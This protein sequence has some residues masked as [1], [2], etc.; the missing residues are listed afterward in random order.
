MKIKF[1][2][3]VEMA[4][5]P[6]VEQKRFVGGVPQGW[7]LMFNIMGQVDSTALDIVLT[8]ENMSELKFLNDSDD[9]ITTTH[10]YEKVLSCTI[11]HG[12]SPSDTRTEIQLMKN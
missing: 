6:P 4:C 2:N 9:V 8:T 3:N 1:K 10:N 11:R 7:V 12:D 5:T